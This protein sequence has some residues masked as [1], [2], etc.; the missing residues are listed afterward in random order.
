MP[1]FGLSAVPSPMKIR[2]M[3]PGSHAPNADADGDTT[4]DPTNRD[5]GSPLVT[6]AAAATTGNDPPNSRRL[7]PTAGHPDRPTTEPSPLPPA[8]NHASTPALSPLTPPAT[9]ARGVAVITG[10]EP[11]DT[12]PTAGADIPSTAT[13]GES[14]TATTESAESKESDRGIASSATEFDPDLRVDGLTSAERG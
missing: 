8:P 4:A 6:D 10:A 2:R 13:S 11:R 12:T 14:V 3:L 9:A 7:A 1:A 5:T